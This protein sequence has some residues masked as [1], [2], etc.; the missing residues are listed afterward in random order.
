MVMLVIDAGK[1]LKIRPGDVVGAITGTSDIPADALGKIT[2]LPFTSYVA[3]QRASSKAA[4]HHLASGTIK[5][6]KI[7]VR[8]L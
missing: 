1:K 3:V 4:L 5:G 6:K 2:I 8:L 7:K